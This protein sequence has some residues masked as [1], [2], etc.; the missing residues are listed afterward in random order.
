MRSRSPVQ[1]QRATGR[2]GFRKRPGS[3][4]ANGVVQ[5]LRPRTLARV[6]RRLVVDHVLQRRAVLADLCAGRVSAIEVCDATPYLLRAAKYH[7]ERTEVTC[8]VCRRE[9]VWHVNYVY[10][11]ELKAV[12]GQARRTAELKPMEARY[13]AFSV[14]VVEVCPGCGW[15]HLAQ[16]FV[17]GTG[18]PAHDDCLV[19]R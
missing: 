2:A 16:S 11:D 5:A 12:A 18:A 13:T 8:P 7:G 1:Q 19:H 3:A 17:L 4:S 15:N 6:N 9:P 10:G 14:Y